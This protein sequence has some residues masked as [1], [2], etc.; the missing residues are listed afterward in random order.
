M[1]KRCVPDDVMNKRRVP[2]G[3]Y[4]WVAVFACFLANLLLVSVT[5][6]LVIVTSFL[7]G[8]TSLGG[9][10]VSVAASIATSTLL[11]AE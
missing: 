3:G 6:F 7:V 10:V 1:D 8:V 9:C 2:D 4:G 5:S 11:V